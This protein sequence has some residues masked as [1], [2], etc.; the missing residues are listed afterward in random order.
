MSSMYGYKSIGQQGGQNINNDY[1]EST[2]NI[3]LPEE[4]VTEPVDDKLLKKFEEIA[5]GF[6]F[7]KND[8][9]VG[10]HDF[11]IVTAPNGET[12]EIHLDRSVAKERTRIET[13]QL[14]YYW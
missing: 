2:G 9:R 3:T 13:I 7:R 14:G 12:T 1:A 11:Y 10:K 4:L 6:S 5:P 8:Q